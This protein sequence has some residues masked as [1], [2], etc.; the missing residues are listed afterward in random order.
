MKTEQHNLEFNKKTI[1]ELNTDQLQSVIGGTF[2]A[3]FSG[4]LCDWLVD[5]LTNP[6]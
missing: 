3:S 4:H 5:R 6:Q 1:S 2:S